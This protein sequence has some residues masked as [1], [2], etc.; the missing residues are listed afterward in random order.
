M[1]EKR[2]QF[3]FVWL[4]AIIAGSAI[5][6]LAIYG[7][8]R[9]SQT[10]RY[11]Q[12][13]EIAAALEIVLD[14]MQSLFSEGKLN[15]IPLNR[16]TRLQNFCYLTDGFGK[17]EISISTKSRLGK[18][19]LQQAGEISIYNKYIFSSDLESKR[20]YVFSKPFYLPYK[21]A[22]LIFIYDGEYCFLHT[23]DNLK[24]EIERFNSPTL[25]VENCS[26]GDIRVCFSTGDDCDMNVV[27]TCT[28]GCED[29]LETGY[30]SK[31]GEELSFVGNL[32]WAAI[33]S[34]KYLYECNVDRLLY[35]TS[36]LGIVLAKK[37][38]LMESRGVNN[39]LVVALT[40]WAERTNEMGASR[41]VQNYIVVK[42]LE[43]RHKD[44]VLSGSELW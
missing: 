11:Q 20:F 38:E 19:W 23:P 32:M 39:G 43:Q 7:A 28:Y 10:A 42:T 40:D 41:L 24:K 13:T 26:E 34:D 1:T 18:E 12:D 3:N 22:D 21:V 35:R 29:L 44:E 36:T 14:P 31:D 2:A 27:G 17:N 5:L 6:V 4:F 9:G 30:V 8:V 37:A 33:F 15:S 16:E 25:K